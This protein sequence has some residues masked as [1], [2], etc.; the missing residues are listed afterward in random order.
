MARSNL[1]TVGTTPTLLNAL[2][3]SSY[4]T[5]A[6]AF[7]VPAGSTVYVG[8]SAVTT[9]NGF[10]VTATLTVDLA[11]QELIY[12]VAAASVSGVRVLQTGI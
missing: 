3:D 4:G 12:G 8:D 6:I 2:P 7:T 9:T 1:V 11:D 5:S 10:P